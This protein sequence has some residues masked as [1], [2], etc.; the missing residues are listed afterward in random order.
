MRIRIR[1]T[2][3]TTIRI[4]TQPSSSKYGTNWYYIVEVGTGFRTQTHADST[5]QVLLVIQRKN[6]HEELVRHSI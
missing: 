4:R 1:N 2:D 3:L 5:K 6:I